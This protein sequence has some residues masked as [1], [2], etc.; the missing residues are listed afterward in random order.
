MTALKILQETEEILPTVDYSRY[1][2]KHY[3]C[4]RK[5]DAPPDR[6]WDE[7]FLVQFRLSCHPD[8]KGWYEQSSNNEK[9]NV[10]DF[11]DV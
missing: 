6:I 10:L 9:N 8:R 4:G 7:C 11:S 1:E 2:E 3:T 5:G